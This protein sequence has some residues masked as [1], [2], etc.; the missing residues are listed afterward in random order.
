MD[1]KTSV[2]VLVP[3]LFLRIPIEAAVRAFGCLPS[4]AADV[5]AAVRALPRVVVADL[6]VLGDDPAAAVRELTRAGKTV[7]AFG[8]H[9]A[10]EKLAS[11]RAAGAV[12]LPR[13]V[14]LERLPELLRVALGGVDGDA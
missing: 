10:G 9:V 14:F 3:N 2:S 5:V 6:E 8:P 12:V 4:V 1:E 11:A 7:L 13:S